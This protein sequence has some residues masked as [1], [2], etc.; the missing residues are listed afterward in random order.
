MNSNTKLIIIFIAIGCL[1]ASNFYQC[2]RSK[3]LSKEIESANGDVYDLERKVNDLESI[4]EDLSSRID[5]TES[6][7]DDLETK[8]RRIRLYSDY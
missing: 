3:K 2:T 5:D 1:I 8:V 7:I 6:D 4:L